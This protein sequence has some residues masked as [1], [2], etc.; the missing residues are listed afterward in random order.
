MTEFIDAV[1]QYGFM[2]NALTAGLLAAVACGVV[3]SFVVARRVSYVAG[4]IAHSVLGGM[5]AAGYLAAVHGWDGITPLHGAIVA[6]LLS[7]LVI[8]WVTLR[9]RQ[10]EDTIIGAVW[11]IGMAVGILFISRTPGYNRELMSYLFGNILMVT[12]TDLVVLLVLD[13]L[14]VGLA[15]L[16]YNRFLAVCFDAEFARVRGVR[17]ETTY[18]LLLSLTALTVVVLVTIVGVVLVIALLTL[19]AA[20]AGCFSRTFRQMMLGAVFCC[21]LFSVSGLAVSY[22]TNFPAGATIVLLAGACYVVVMAGKWLIR[23]KRNSVARRTSPT[24]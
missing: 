7:A 11:A 24:S 9:A 13:L 10:R 23:G 3:G 1:V 17:V 21:A 8:G 14:I 12:D 16:F 4:G 22:Q 19:P 5:G 20:V 15:L 2:R 6:A 18:L